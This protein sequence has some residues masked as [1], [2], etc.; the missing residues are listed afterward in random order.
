MWFMQW[1]NQ[2]MSMVVGGIASVIA[3][4]L[5]GMSMAA[6]YAYGKKKYKLPPWN[7]IQ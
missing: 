3:G 6:Y 2:G 5:F 7:E 1:S 4:V